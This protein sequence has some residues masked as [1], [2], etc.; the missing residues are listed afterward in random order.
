[1]KYLQ[2]NGVTL[3]M[4][5]RDLQEEIRAANKEFIVQAEKRAAEAKI[6]APSK[7]ALSRWEKPLP[8]V[9]RD[10]LSRVALKMF[11]S[12]AKIRFSG[13]WV[14]FQLTLLRQ[15][16]LAKV[17]RTLTPTG[18]G[19]LLLGAAPREVLP[20]AGLKGTIKYP[21]GTEEVRDFDEPLI[22]IPDHVEAWLKAKL[23][24]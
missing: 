9:S 19:F 16:F 21:D 14:K 18:Y 22:L 17:G 2:E 12:K 24:H 20:Q 8:M 23:P 10:D 5:D 15:G 3:H 13:N 1:M 6:A 7:I 11:R 4:F